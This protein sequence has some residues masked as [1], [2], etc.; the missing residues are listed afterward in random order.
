MYTNP[1]F[2][3][4]GQTDD[5]LPA[6]V[7]LAA[8]KVHAKSFAIFSCAESPSC[9]ELGTPE[10]TAA[11]KYGEKLSYITQISAS[12][13][14]FAAPCLAAKQ[15]GATVLFVADAVN[16]VEAVAS[17]CSSQGYTPTIVASDGAVGKQF[18]QIPS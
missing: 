12:V 10:K 7:V 2:F 15:A 6:A 9:Q 5:S 3:F 8:K 13:P 4:P 17:S 1:D 16:V 11:A 18:P 14:S